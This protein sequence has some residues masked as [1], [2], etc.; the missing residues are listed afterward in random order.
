MASE[1]EEQLRTLDFKIG[2]LKRDYEQ[3]FLG[4]RPREPVMLA[5]EVKKLVVVLTQTP[6]NNTALKFRFSSL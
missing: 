4:T 1:V 2:Q 6:F 3:Y 5:G